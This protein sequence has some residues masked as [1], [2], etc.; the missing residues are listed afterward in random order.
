MLAPM[1]TPQDVRLVQE[2]FAAVEPIADTAAALF[3][4]RLFELDP[5]LRPLFRRDMKTQGNRL[6]HILGVA[7][8][9]LDDLSALVPVVEQLG[10]RHAAY[11]VRPEHYTTVAEA[12]L[13]TLQTGL[14]PAFTPSVRDA[15]VN[16]YGLL[17]GTMQRGAAYSD[18][19]YASAA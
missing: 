12:L 6:M 7:I 2:S 3:Y 14:G 4:A 15:W 18:D 9:G 11:G 13:W 10:K 8:T 19:A 17:A 1:M 5:S 16:V